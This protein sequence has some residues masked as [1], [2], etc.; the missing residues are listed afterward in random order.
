MKNIE[1]RLNVFYDMFLIN[2]VSFTCWLLIVYA[3]NIG[4]I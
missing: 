2:S 1:Q 3:M 4:E